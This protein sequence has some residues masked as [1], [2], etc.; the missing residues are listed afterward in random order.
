MS[1]NKNEIAIVK[2]KKAWYALVFPFA[3]FCVALGVLWN[4][5]EVLVSEKD[6]SF[7][8]VVLGWS[9]A[10]FLFVILGVVFGMVRD[11]HFDFK[12][13]RYKII[14][15]VGI[16]GFGRWKQFHNLEYVS[17]FENPDSRFEI[18]LWY[19]TTKHFYIDSYFFSEAAVK[20]ARELAQ[21]LNIEFHNG[22]TNQQF[23]MEDDTAAPI[24]K[25]QRK[26]DA[27]FSQGNRPLWQTIVAAFCF[28][29]SSVVLY[30]M[31]FE[32]PVNN[33]N[34]RLPLRS[35]EIVLL[36][37][38]T[39]I[40]FSMVNDYLFDLENNQFKVIHVIGFIK[41][42]TWKQLASL[43]YISVYQKKEGQFQINLWYNTNKHIHISGSNEYKSALNIGEQLAKKLQIELLDASD[44]HHKKWVELL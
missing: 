20:R 17:V 27:Y 22:M 13:K 3:C 18:N 1:M 43:D 10:A 36:L 25:E 28:T 30:A 23:V 24:P 5:Y 21:Q 44:P 9:F 42:G 38:I 16:L 14:K 37:M 35:I 26:I 11:Y 31:F 41:W 12:R 34:Y 40:R 19:D 32:I 2:G 15:R 7:V 8:E 6:V 33:Q 29:V 39:G 4:G